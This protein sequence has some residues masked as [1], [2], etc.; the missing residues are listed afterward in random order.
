MSRVMMGESGFGTLDHI[1]QE[2]R[3][4]VTIFCECFVYAGTRIELIVTRAGG[5]GRITRKKNRNLE[6][7]G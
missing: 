7:S 6:V 4:I 5:F 2:Q 3:N 1:S